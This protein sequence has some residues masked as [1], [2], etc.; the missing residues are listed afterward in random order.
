M[1]S[2]KNSN[3]L[4]AVSSTNLQKTLGKQATDVSPRI[5]RADAS[6][7]RARILVA[8]KKLFE[9][10]GVANVTTDDIARAA[11]VGK[12]TLFRRFAS[13]SDLCLALLE[14]EL[15]AFQKHSM[16]Q[17]KRLAKA[18]KTNLEQLGWLMETIVRFNETHLDLLFEANTPRVHKASTEPPL[19]K[20]FLLVYELLEQ[21]KA[22]NEIS[23]AHQLPVL[24]DLLLAPIHPPMLRFHRQLRGYSILSLIEELTCVVKGLET[25][26]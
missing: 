13:K 22:A 4:D 18:G 24:A 6:A 25:K 23:A 3:T 14:D 26:L 10:Y 5:E 7:N 15:L 2:P 12:G 20:Q 9:Q 11:K 21:A 1:S 8:S 19:Q 17:I 16:R